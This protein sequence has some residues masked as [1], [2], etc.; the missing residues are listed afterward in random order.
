VLCDKRNQTTRVKQ[1]WQ[2]DHQGSFIIHVKL[3]NTEIRLEC[4]DGHEFITIQGIVAASELQ[5][6]DLIEYEY[7]GNLT[8]GIVTSIIVMPSNSPIRLIDI[9]TESGTFLHVS[10]LVLHNSGKSF[11]SAE[12]AAYLVHRFLCLDGVPCT[13]YGLINTVLRGVFVAGD[14]SQAAETVWGYFA[15]AIQESPW[16]KVY[17]AMLNDEEKKKGMDLYKFR[18]DGNLAF[19][20]KKL[21]FSRATSDQATLRGRSRIIGSIDE[22][23]WFDNREGA[24]RRAGKEVYRAIDNSMQT[25]RSSAEHRWNEGFYDLPTAFMLN[26]SSPSAEDDPIMSIAAEKRNSKVTYIF[27]LPTWEINPEITLE[28]LEDQMLTDPIGTMRDFGAQPGSGK[29]V[30]FPNPDTVYALIDDDRESLLKYHK[31]SL[32]VQVKEI[33]YNYVKCILDKVDI[34]RTT[35]YI[36]ACDAGESNNSFSLLLASLDNDVSIVNSGVIIQPEALS[37]GGVATVH[38]PS[39]LDFITDLRKHIS[40]EMV[41]F[42]RW[43]STLVIQG[44]RDQGVDARKHTLKYDEFKAFKHRVYEEHIRIPKLEVPFSKIL[45][46]KLTDAQPMASLAKQLRTVR[47][48]GRKITKP[49]VGDDDLFRCLVLADLYMV[50]NKEKFSRRGFEVNSTSKFKSFYASVNSIQHR[51]ANRMGMNTMNAHGVFIQKGRK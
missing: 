19:F 32:K 2:S 39:V 5:T 41:V 38:F 34:D 16:F 6:S 50:E 17:F 51:G 25:I 36:L 43:Q 13:R 29:H 44:L 10:G 7:R 42:D 4:S 18:P 45:L 12:F 20:H 40:L 46:Q 9:E 48:T 27:H 35:P 15:A 24:K 47:D 33:E 14:S 26:V 49:P 30:M 22:L 23:G 28:G 37:N 3:P 21:E 31:E 11:L 8:W 1:V